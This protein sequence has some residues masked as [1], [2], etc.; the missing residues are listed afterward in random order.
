[1]LLKFLRTKVT[2]LLSVE[3]KFLRMIIGV[4][5]FKSEFSFV[6]CKEFMA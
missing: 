6:K 2:E 1:M 3:Y 4:S 5:V